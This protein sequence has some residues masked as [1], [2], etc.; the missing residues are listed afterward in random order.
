[1][2]FLGFGLHVN[3][4]PTDWK[5]YA[6]AVNALQQARVNVFTLDISDADWHTLEGTLMLFA[7]M[8]GGPTKRRTSSR[9]RPWSW[10]SVRSRGATSSSS[11]GPT[12]PAGARPSS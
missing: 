4:Q 10:R 2:L 9:A 5:W 12:G 11:P 3:R 8:T 1:M 6:L 7:D